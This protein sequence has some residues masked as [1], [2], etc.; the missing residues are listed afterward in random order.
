[1]S[2]LAA[3][4]RMRPHREVTMS[5]LQALNLPPLP[6]RGAAP[7]PGK[8]VAEAK[9]VASGARTERLSQ[10]AETW[11]ETHRQADERIK[12]LKQSI[13]AH[14]ADGH[15]QLL[16]E[17]D[18]GLVKLDEVLDNIDHRL[19]DALTNA[20]K[21]ADDGARKTELKN[22][23]SLLTEYI[24]YVKSEPLIAHMDENP[25]DVQTGL[26][27]LLVGGLTQAAMAIG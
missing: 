5:L 13:Q 16:Q 23:K 11:R 4:F 14:Y 2:G 21:A 7:V 10:S 15:P 12:A 18:K 25:F 24:N 26:K 1:M 3:A 22:A 19:A 20:S 6:P 8:N 27:K 9:A 17:I